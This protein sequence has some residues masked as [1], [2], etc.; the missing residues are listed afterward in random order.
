[1]KKKIAKILRTMGSLT[2]VMSILL[3]CAC[4]TKETTKKKKKKKKT[5]TTEV[6]E[7]VEP[8]D[9]PTE[10][11]D[12]EPTNPTDPT[13]PTLPEVEKKYFGE[14]ASKRLHELDEELFYYS[15]DGVD[16]MTMGNYMEDP[17]AYGLEWSDVALPPIQLEED[18]E[19]VEE[20]KEYSYNF[21]V[22]LLEIDEDSL[23]LYDKFLYENYLYS[24]EFSM[25]GDW[26]HDDYYI[27][28][29]SS[30]G[31]NNVELPLGLALQQFDDDGDVERY[32]QIIEDSGAF[33][34][35]MFEYEK[36]R[37]ELGYSLPDD[38]LNEIIEQLESVVSDGG[39]LY[40]TFEDRINAMDMGADKKEEYIA[41]NKELLDTVFFPAYERLAQNMKTLLGTTKTDGRMCEME[42]GKDYYEYYFQMKSGTNLTVSEGMDLLENW[43]CDLYA[44]AQEYMNNMSTDQLMNVFGEYTYSM[45]TL[46]DNLAFCKEK[47]KNDFPDQGEIPYTTVRMPSEFS[48]SY[49][50]AAYSIAPIDAPE[51]NVILVQD[52]DAQGQELNT[53]AHEAFP[54]H[55]Y[56]RYYTLNNCDSYFSITN[57][58]TAYAESWSTYC[59]N[60]I[61]Q[62]TDCDYAV[63][64]AYYTLFWTCIVT[65]L[66]TYLDM[67]VHY[68]GWTIQEAET[69]MMKAFPQPE[70]SALIPTIVT[71]YYTLVLELPCYATPYAFGSYYSNKIIGD[72]VA[73]YGDEY[74]MCEIHK[75]YLDMGPSNFYLLSEY[76]PLFVE[77]QHKP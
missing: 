50:S 73:K 74:T 19:A 27:S 70:I 69:E 40:T 15:F 77:E 48:G 35:S 38:C 43:V 6:T 7:T 11:S 3:S 1:M 63:Y 66:P 42:G 60:Y 47:I 49:A 39:Y 36:K 14:E 13:E 18:E 24:L 68:Y 29:M 30:F 76:M 72:A 34:D 8:T 56:Q 41:R 4:S 28:S 62:F 33:L 26:I 71:S 20:D 21:L 23:D 32:L 52:E 53:A 9:E 22:S 51:K 67:G 58:D 65:V 37:A 61:M 17:E 12:T 54:G 64:R 44:E 46:E 31:G 75:A 55:M 25:K 5:T 59:E 2:I 10:T 45:G 57:Y 16:Q